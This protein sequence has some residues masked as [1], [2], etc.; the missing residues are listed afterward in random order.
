MDA[1]YLVQPNGQ[2]LEY[3][4]I[5]L[6]RIKI[7]CIRDRI[8]ASQQA[9]SPASKMLQEQQKFAGAKQNLACAEISIIYVELTH[10]D[11]WSSS[12]AIA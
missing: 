10:T 5:R 8:L 9:M 6:S 3:D 4:P 2:L 1:L 11:D 12:W 7:C